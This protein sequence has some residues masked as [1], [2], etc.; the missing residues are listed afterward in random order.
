MKKK[1]KKKASV[2]GGYRSSFNGLE[3]ICIKGLDEDFSSLK[4]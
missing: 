4:L 3:L 2:N 1:E